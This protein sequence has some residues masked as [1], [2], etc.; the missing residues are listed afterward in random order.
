MPKDEDT[1]AVGT[2]DSIARGRGRSALYWLVPALTFLVGLA[3]GAVVT[4]ATTGDDGPAETL[5][6]VAATPSPA[7][8][9][10]SPAPATPTDDATIVVPAACIRTAQN[11]QEAVALMRRS[12]EAAR[13]LDAARLQQIVDQM[14]ALQPRIQESATTCQTAALTPGPR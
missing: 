4:A 2:A 3:L 9:P 8:T 12:V 7:R 13:D 11:A 1:P 5:P 14:E 6:P 10:S